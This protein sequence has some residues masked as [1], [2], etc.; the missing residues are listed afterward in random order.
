MKHMAASG[1]DV[2]PEQWDLIVERADDA[3]EELYAAWSRER[4][5]GKEERRAHK[6]AMEA[7]RAERAAPGSKGDLERADAAWLLLRSAAVVV[8]QEV[9][10]RR[11]KPKD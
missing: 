2:M 1:D 6:A 4:E 10:E 8:M 9:V 7:L 5:A 3:A 11:P